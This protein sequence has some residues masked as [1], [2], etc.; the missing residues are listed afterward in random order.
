MKPLGEG[1]TRL[2]LALAIGGTFTS[3]I[4]AE[5]DGLAGRCLL[6]EQGRHLIPGGYVVLE[7]VHYTPDDYRR[8]VRMG[9]NFQVIRTPLGQLG[10]WPGVPPKPDCLE[11]FDAM[12]RMGKDAGLRTVFKLV[13]YG[14]RPFGNE[15]WD[16]LWHNANGSQDTLL[17][18]WGKLWNRYKDDP[19]VFGYDLLNEPQRGLDPD[20][21]RCQRENLLPLLR[22]LTD[23]M[24]KISPEKWALYQP[25]LR[26]PE[27]QWNKGKNPAVA[28]EEPFGRERIIYAPHLYRMETPLIVAILDDFQRQAAISKAPLL[29]GEWGA[30][31]RSTTDEDPTEQARYTKAY[32][33]T[34]NELDT[35]GIGG[36]KAWFCGFRK[37]IPVQGSTNWITW[38]IFSDD[39][40]AGRVER[41]YITDVLARPRPLV[42]AGRLERYGNDFASLNFETTLKTDPAL[43]VTEIFVPADRLYPR[44]FRVEVGPGLTL[45]HDPGT[46][47]L[48]TVRA[49]GAANSEQA[50]QV[51]WDNDTQHLLIEKWVGNAQRLTVKV[52]PEIKE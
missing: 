51:R 52:M 40:P 6:D 7:N 1:F 33:V 38:A 28:I 14:I 16:A 45:A 15:Q 43:G 26:K 13:V 32:Q 36:I 22:R 44:G 47:L 31:T 41:K 9:A 10:G 18:A 4:G 12:V 17:A 27:D 2:L 25:L 29:L 48:R 23:A 42:V 19:S 50:K 20:Y 3:A 39:T 49:A 35:R 8:M 34:A 21:D 46:T 24:H 11:Q 37:P 30:P 5:A